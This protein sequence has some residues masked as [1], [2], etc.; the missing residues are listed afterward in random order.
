MQEGLY[1]MEFHTAHGRGNGVLYVTA[2]KLRGGNSGFAFMGSYSDRGDE[3]L[4]RVSTVRHTEDPG[5]KPLF[6]IDNV[7]LTLKGTKSGDMI[8]FEGSALQMPGV[9]FKALLTRICD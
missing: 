2:G 9:A 8:D 6:G 4:A 5:F 1:K 7:T 3:I